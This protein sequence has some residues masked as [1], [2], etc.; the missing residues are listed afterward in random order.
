[1]DKKQL[2]TI[3]AMN[4]LPF[5]ETLIYTDAQ[6]LADRYKV[7]RSTIDR[8]VASEQFPLTIVSAHPIKRWHIEEL[9][10]FE[11]ELYTTFTCC[12]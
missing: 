1:M 2:K 11:H 10:E 3:A 12:N 5:P 4:G 9:K 6:T 8:W 7:G